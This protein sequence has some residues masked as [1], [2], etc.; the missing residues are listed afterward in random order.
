MTYYFLLVTTMAITPINYIRKIFNQ[1][2][3]LPAVTWGFN[4]KYGKYRC[5]SLI[6]C[7]ERSQN[8][9]KKKNKHIKSDF[10]YIDPVLWDH[11][12]TYW[13]MLMPSN[14]KQELIPG[15]LSLLS[16]TW[17]N[18]CL[19]ISLG[20]SW[21]EPL[22]VCWYFLIK[23]KATITTQSFWILSFLLDVGKINVHLEC[24]YKI[25]YVYCIHE[26]IKKKNQL[27]TKVFLFFG[28]RHLHF[29]AA[30]EWLNLS[31]LY[32]WKVS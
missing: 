29:K 13:L 25:R 19:R 7:T 16:L 5:N 30:K 27:I 14:T 4:N 10:V 31:R 12:D 6:N 9:I 24:R 15:K 21:F 26:Y 1:G 28:H 2:A 23:S 17:I 32:N 20:L 3:S 8:V 11:A 18:N 22:D